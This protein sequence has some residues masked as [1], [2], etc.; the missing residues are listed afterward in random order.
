VLTQALAALF[1]AGAL[2]DLTSFLPAAGAGEKRRARQRGVRG[3]RGMS[4]ARWLAGR[5]RGCAPRR[6]PALPGRPPPGRSAAAERGT[7]PVR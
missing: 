5:Y 2:T 3:G 6:K 1:T 7:R 4:G